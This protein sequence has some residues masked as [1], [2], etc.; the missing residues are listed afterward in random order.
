MVPMSEKRLDASIRRAEVIAEEAFLFIVM[1]Q[2]RTRDFNEARDR[3][4]LYGV[5]RGRRA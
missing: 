3:S 4:W 5:G 1:A 2:K